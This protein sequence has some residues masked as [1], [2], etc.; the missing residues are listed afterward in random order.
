MSSPPALA[1]AAPES[2][3]RT[4]I[5]TFIA[6]LPYTGRLGNDM[7][8]QNRLNDRWKAKGGVWK[9]GTDLIHR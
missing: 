1:D 8:K 7:A 4:V 3:S 2:S 6:S 5:T 9:K